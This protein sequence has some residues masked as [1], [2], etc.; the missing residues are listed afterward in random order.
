MSGGE[1]GGALELVWPGRGWLEGG[2][3][4]LDDVGVPRQGEHRPEGGGGQGRQPGL[5]GGVE[6][7]G[8]GG[9]GQSEAGEAKAGR[10]EGRGWQ[11]LQVRG[12][13]SEKFVLK[14]DTEPLTVR[15]KGLEILLM[16]ASCRLLSAVLGT[17]AAVLF[18][19]SAC[20]ASRVPPESASG[21]SVQLS[22]MM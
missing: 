17:K 4:G 3:A 20:H 22:V 8:D 5:Q 10:Q 14:F 15:P 13:E 12:L 11:V 9:V 16:I 7:G 21:G 6:E 1:E 18:I 19:L 2:G